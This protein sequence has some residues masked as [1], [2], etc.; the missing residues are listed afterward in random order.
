[1]P[2][3]MVQF[4][5]KKSVDYDVWPGIVQA[6]GR[7]GSSANQQKRE[8]IQGTGVVVAGPGLAVVNYSLQPTDGN[9]FHDCILRA[10]Q[11][12]LP[13]AAQQEIGD[14]VK[15]EK[16][17]AWYCNSA[18][19]VCEAGGCLVIAYEW[20]YQGEPTDDTGGTTITKVKTTFEWYRGYVTL[21]GSPAACRRI[22]FRI[23]NNLIP[24]YD[25]NSKG[26][27]KRYPTVVAPGAEVIGASA[28]YY[29]DPGHDP[30]A[31]ELEIADLVLV[32]VNNAGTPQTFTF[33]GTDMKVGEC[34]QSLKTSNELYEYECAYALDDNDL[35]GFT[36][37][38]A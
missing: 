23:A 4:V 19:I 14:D 17:D 20:T 32:C 34:N 37:G 29:A 18:E 27:S 7:W 22:A 2:S 8:G 30:T 5:G 11:N 28:V 21:E 1:M 13:T 31:D 12:A 16:G 25:L 38:F 35:T 24:R 10:S 33:T 36:I 9:G 3:G 26:S 15:S 6:G